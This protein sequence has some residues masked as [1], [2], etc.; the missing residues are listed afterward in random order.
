MNASSSKN[1]YIQMQDTLIHDP[2]AICMLVEVI[3]RKSQDD[4]WK[5]TINK[6]K[7]ECERIKRLS[8]DKFYE[9]VTGDRLAFKKLCEKL[10]LV[11]SDVVD[12]AQDSTIQNTVYEEL[13]RISPNLM[14]SI[15]LLSFAKYEGFDELDMPV[16]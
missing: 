3:A 4:I 13:R 14:K 2:D 6:R 7:V 15:Y 16:S 9:F 8:I 11:I 12:D 10:P 1:T 5:K